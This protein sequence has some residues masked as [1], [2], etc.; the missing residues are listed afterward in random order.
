MAISIHNGNLIN[1]GTNIS[2]KTEHSFDKLQL[3]AELND[4]GL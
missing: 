1:V 2:D 3:S 4:P